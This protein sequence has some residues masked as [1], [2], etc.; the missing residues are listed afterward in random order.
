MKA[1][2]PG[3]GPAG[4]PKIQEGSESSWQI[5]KVAL[6]RIQREV[7][8]RYADQWASAGLV[9]RLRLRLR[10]WREI[11]RELERIAPQGGLYL[12][13]RGA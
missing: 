1:E 8:A 13:G 6:A 5:F 11:R 4:W 3:E 7:R 2:R 12:R 9:E 10:I